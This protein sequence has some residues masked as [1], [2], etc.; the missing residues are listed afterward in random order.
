MIIFDA[1]RINTG[2]GKVL[3]EYFMERNKQRDNIIYLLD[4]R[5]H[6]SLIDYSAYK[7]LIK[8][9]N[10]FLP[11]KIK[12]ILNKKKSKYFSFINMPSILIALFQVEQIVY[13]HNS[14]IF[15]NKSLKF[16]LLRFLIRLSY[17]LNKN[18]TFYVQTQTV[19]D[20]FLNTFNFRNVELMPFY[21]S[22]K[23]KKYQK[24]HSLGTPIYDFIYLGLPSGH[25]NH[26]L[27]LDALEIIPKNI[28]FN[29]AMTIP[30]H[31]YVLLNKIKQHNLTNHINIVNLGLLS[32]NEAM[33]ALAK[34]KC[35]IFPSLLETYGLPLIEAQIVGLDILASN[36]SY[37]NDVIEPTD[38]FNP[39]DK[40]DIKNCITRYILN[41]NKK[42]PK[43]KSFNKIKD[44]EKVLFYNKG[45]E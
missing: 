25:K 29:I 26:E 7:Y 2:G 1:S 40:M 11:S 41:K 28:I 16:A 43:L 44:I 15:K 38:I 3:L 39:L 27:L 17:S 9:K 24:M 42:K 36:L 37:V 10:S 34:S 12:L 23:L 5:L 32:Y 21:D 22:E 35:L 30:E 13:I 18:I 33:E 6:T 45:K 4:N 19:K 20:N 31:E 14:Y 8:G